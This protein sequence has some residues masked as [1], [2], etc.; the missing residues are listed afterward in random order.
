MQKIELIDCNKF[1]KEFIKRE[2][3][4]ILAN[5]EP[6]EYVAIMKLLNDCVVKK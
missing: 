4:P 5:I 2:R 6:G 3:Y 1:V